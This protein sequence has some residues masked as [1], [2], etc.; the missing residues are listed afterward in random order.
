MSEWNIWKSQDIKNY[1]FAL[2]GSLPYWNYAKGILMAIPMYDYYVE[3]AVK[4]GI[5]DSFEYIGRIPHQD[6]NGE[7]VLEPEFTSISDM[8]QKI[9]DS[10]KGSEQSLKS[11]NNGC[12]ISTRY[13]IEYDQE[14]HYI[15]RF[16][17]IITVN[18]DCDWDTTAHE[19]IVSDFSITQSAE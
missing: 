4:D 14:F 16:E 9:Y 10:I 13:E 19:V 6:G 5:M 1:N 8:Y 12:I 3:I 7:S 15:T 11:S 2:E 17:P 18:L